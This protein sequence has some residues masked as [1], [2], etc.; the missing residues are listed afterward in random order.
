VEENPSLDSALEKF[1]FS[2]LP[3]RERIAQIL[4]QALSAQATF[5]PAPDVVPYRL[6]INGVIDFL[7]VADLIDKYSIG[8]FADPFEREVLVGDAAPEAAE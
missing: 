8:N 2:R 3:K 7:S 1:S 4:V 6:L 5:G